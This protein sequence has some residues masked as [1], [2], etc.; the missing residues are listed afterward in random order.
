MGKA[1]TSI[2]LSAGIPNELSAPHMIMNAYKM[3]LAIGI[4]AKYDFPELKNAL[5]ANQAAASK[6]PAT[7]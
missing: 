1:M 5:S 2:S 4:E 6:S 7:L 3:L